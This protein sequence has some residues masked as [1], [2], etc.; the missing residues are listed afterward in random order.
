MTRLTAVQV[1]R[2]VFGVEQAP[3]DYV[4]RSCHNQLPDFPHRQSRPPAS[5]PVL[6]NGAPCRRG[7]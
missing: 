7:Q 2:R 1:R 6:N 3:D 5:F 4:C